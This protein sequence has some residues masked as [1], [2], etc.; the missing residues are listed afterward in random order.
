MPTTRLQSGAITRVSISDPP[1]P[2]SPKESPTPNDPPVRPVQ[3]EAPEN[4]TEYE[5]WLCHG[6][7]V[8][9]YG[10]AWSLILHSRDS[11]QCHYYTVIG[12]IV[13]DEETGHPVTQEPYDVIHGQKADYAGV[14]H[15]LYRTETF[16]GYLAAERLAEWNTVYW[17][18]PRGPNQ[19]FFMRFLKSVMEAGIY[20][21]GFSFYSLWEGEKPAYWDVEMRV[22]GGYLDEDRKLVEEMEEV[23]KGEEGRKVREAVERRERMLEKKKEYDKT[24]DRR[25]GS[26]REKG[27][28]KEDEME[29]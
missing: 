28:M 16:C 4:P 1:P 25:N 27:S 7:P 2:S 23:G 22:S 19:F 3:P 11:P 9:H 12:S 13:V 8:P 5:V 17:N 6:R 18:T 24:R 21:P 15:D 10:S 14:T 29:T 20:E 26:V